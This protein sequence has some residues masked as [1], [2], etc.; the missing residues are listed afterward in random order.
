MREGIFSQVSSSW[1]GV[2]AINQIGIISLYFIAEIK[3]GFEE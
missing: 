1:K 2:L 3:E